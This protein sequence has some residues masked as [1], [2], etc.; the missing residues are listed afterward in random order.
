MT[1]LRGI[2]I[3][4]RRPDTETPSAPTE[5]PA[6]WA[7][8]AS[9]LHAAGARGSPPINLRERRCETARAPQPAKPGKVAPC[10]PIRWPFSSHSASHLSRSHTGGPPGIT[11]YRPYDGSANLP[12]PRRLGGT[13]WP[14]PSS[15]S[16]SVQGH[17]VACSTGL[18]CTQTPPADH[19]LGG[20]ADS[21]VAPPARHLLLVCRAHL[22]RRGV[23]WLHLRPPPSP[24]PVILLREMA[25]GTLVG[26][27]RVVLFLPSVENV[28]GHPR[29]ASTCEGPRFRGIS[30][31]PGQVAI[32]FVSTLFLPYIC[33]VL[34]AV[35]Y[36]DQ[37][38]PW[39]SIAPRGVFAGAPCQR[40]SWSP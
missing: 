2:P 28:S 9:P 6:G 10:L 15:P 30:I 36:S 26:S 37:P 7:P 1:L 5:M 31:S 22:A 19:G 24:L 29:P 18:R 13:K 16:H 35:R 4:L 21:S 12:C 3:P 27:R 17:R 25:D 39:Q 32:S 20:T 38:L 40:A 14:G 8:A 34:I 33:L 23:S 11:E